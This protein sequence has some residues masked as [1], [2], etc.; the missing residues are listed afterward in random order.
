MHDLFKLHSPDTPELVTG[1]APT[2]VIKESV[3]TDSLLEPL[4]VEKLQ[5]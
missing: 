3:R 5:V 2:A 1:P 4:V